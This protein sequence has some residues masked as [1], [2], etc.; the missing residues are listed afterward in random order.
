MKTTLQG[1]LSGNGIE[2]FVYGYNTKVI[3]NGLIPDL[4]QA[5]QS[6]ISRLRDFAFACPKRKAAYKA[7]AGN[8]EMDQLV[9][10]ARCMFGNLDNTPDFALDGSVN[11]EYVEC[12]KRHYCKYVGVGCLPTKQDVQLSKREQTL[13]PFMHLS[14]KEIGEKLFISVHTVKSHIRSINKKLK[15]TRKGQVILMVT[16]KA[17][18]WK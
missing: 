17:K 5:D 14:N 10:C 11:P 2:I 12:G 4:P 15:T 3:Q 9:Q 1:I 7:M 6:I 18:Q 16:E 13:I 8:N